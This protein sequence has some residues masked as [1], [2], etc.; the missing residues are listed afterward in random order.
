MRSAPCLL[1]AEGGFLRIIPLVDADVSGINAILAKYEDQG[2]QLADAALMHLAAR[3]GISHVFT[4][5][6]IDF[7]LYRTP[8][9]HSLHI[10]PDLPG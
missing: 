6:R 8:A 9:G 5:D 4:L 3:E 2:F 1:P 7:T 10:I